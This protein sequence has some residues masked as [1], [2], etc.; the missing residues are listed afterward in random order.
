[1][2]KKLLQRFRIYF[3][4]SVK[5]A[6]VL[7]TVSEYIKK[8]ILAYIP[9]ARN[10]QIKVAENGKPLWQLPKEDKV[11]ER[12]LFLFFAGNFEP[13]KNILNLIK[14]MEL[15]YQ[16]NIVI[17]LHISGNSGWE[18]STIHEYIR[19]SSIKNEIVFLGYLSEQQ[20]IEKYCNCKALIFPSLY[21]GFGMPVVEALS[22]DCLVLTS[23]GTVM[24]EICGRAAIYFDPLE[25]RDIADKIKSVFD[26]SFDRNQYL[27]HRTDVLN[28]FDW[29]KTAEI[30]HQEITTKQG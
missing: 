16:Q 10:K 25:P 23:K 2:D 17:Q 18:N 19:N 28:R 20:L 5:R 4:K 24:E 1:M 3:A 26:L 13:R 14:A 7:V 29:K 8:E 11:E 6:T 15:L 30:I 12:T 9:E 27:L 21:E 22:L